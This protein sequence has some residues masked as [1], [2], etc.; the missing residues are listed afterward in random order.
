M[1][2]VSEGSFAIVLVPYLNLNQSI[3]FHAA[4][5]TKAIHQMTRNM[6]N[7]IKQLVYAKELL[8][9]HF[10]SLNVDF[11]TISSKIAP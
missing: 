2:R 4:F 10:S 9:G 1:E 8:R 6:L 3:L 11:T 7:F 5:L